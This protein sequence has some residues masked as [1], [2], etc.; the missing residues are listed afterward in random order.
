MVVNVDFLSRIASNPF[1]PFI[2]E[3]IDAGI[4]DPRPAAA[5]P[6]P[7]VYGKVIPIDAAEREAFLKELFAEPEAPP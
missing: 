2:L 5:T 7:A 6:V 3:R 4:R 1:F